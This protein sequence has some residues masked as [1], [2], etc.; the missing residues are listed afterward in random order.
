MKKMF[1]TCPAD[2]EKIEGAGLVLAAVN[3][4]AFDYINI[5]AS[6]PASSTA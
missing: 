6:S 2:T 5:I 3:P 4:Q 1:A